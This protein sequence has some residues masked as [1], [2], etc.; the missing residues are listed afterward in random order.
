MSFPVTVGGRVVAS[1][2]E[3]AALAQADANGPGGTVVPGLRPWQWIVGLVQAGALDP[4][5]AMGL[6]A[7]LLQNANPVTVAEGARLAEAL[8]PSP[9]DRLVLLALD[10]H[11]AALLL[12]NDPARPEFSVEDSLLRSA[13]AVAPLDNDT[14]RANL[15]T[16]LRHAGLPELELIVLLAHGSPTEIALWMP[17]LLEEGLDEQGWMLVRGRAGRDDEVAGWLKENLAEQLEPTS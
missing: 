14:V 9:L 10:A 4:K 11:D 16:R 6:G 7:A 1:P 8:H 5:L 17:A 15:L 12:Q 2:P 13:A 3:L